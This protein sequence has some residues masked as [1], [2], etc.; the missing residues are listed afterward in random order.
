MSTATSQTGKPQPGSPQTSAT[1]RRP[2][3]K[4]W[5]RELGWRHV[6][7]VLG[8]I[9]AGFPIIYILSASLNPRGTLTGSNQLFASI[10][11]QNYADLGETRFLTWLGNSVMIAI[12]TSIATGWSGAA[13]A[14]AFSDRKS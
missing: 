1:Q 8:V 12:V 10:T 3:R 14:Y 9:Y 2:Q 11:G 6:V 7:G 13:A 5:W 4:T